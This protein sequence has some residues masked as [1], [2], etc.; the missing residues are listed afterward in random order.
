MIFVGFKFAPIPNWDSIMTIKAPGNYKRQEA[1]DAYIAKRHA[2]L[3]AGEAAV[4]LLTGSVVQIAY[5][6]DDELAG[7]RTAE[8][9]EVLK[10]FHELLMA[11]TGLTPVV[12]YRI[13]RAMK[14]LALQNAISDEP[15]LTV[16]N[17][18]TID[19]MYNRPNG[20]IDPVSLMFGTTD[21]DFYSVAARCGI[22]IDASDPVALVEFAKV[23][24]R[25]VDIGQ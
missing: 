5:A 2:E 13:H 12:G 7:I 16:A 18:R 25:N 6:R 21:I 3:E 11:P 15:P 20:F 10:V 4:G 22:P 8:G 23:M 17:I 19:E 9:D 1:I 14:I 24:L